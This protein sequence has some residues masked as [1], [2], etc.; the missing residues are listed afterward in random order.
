MGNSIE[1][2]QR[3][4]ANSV[5]ERLGSFLA[6]SDSRRSKTVELQDA[7]PESMIQRVREEAADSRQSEADKAGQVELSDRERKE[8]DFTKDGVNVPFARSVKG[9]ADNEGVTDWLQ[10]ADFDLSVD[11]NRRVLKDAS[12]EERGRSGLGKSQDKR[13][14]ARTADNKR[15]RRQQA[16]GAKGPAFGGDSE[17][18]GFLREEQQFEDDLFDINLRGDSGPTGQDYNRLEEAHESRSERAKRMD[19]RRS[20]EVTRD[21][22]LWAENKAKYDYP[23]VDTVQPAELHSERSRT[24]R[25]RDEEEQAPIADSRQ[26][27]ALNPDQ[28]D[29]PGVDTKQRPSMGDIK[30]KVEETM[31]AKN[32]VLVEARARGGNEAMRESTLFGRAQSEDVSLDPAEARGEAMTDSIDTTRTDP[33]AGMNAGFADVPEAMEAFAAAEED[34]DTDD[35]GF[36]DGFGDDRDKQGSMLDFGMETDATQHRESRQAEAEASEFG[37]D[38]RSE[39]VFEPMG[40][41]DSDQSGLEGFGGGTRENESLFEDY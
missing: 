2:G 32:D 21:P 30:E 35:S 20:A 41:D 25:R 27:W 36:L 15:K 22:L 6:D 14:I 40:F 18:I 11:E 4:V 17:A 26:Q 5:R 13:D 3:Q 38:D 28:Y 7:V 24:A 39:E 23:G 10:F 29:W 31:M 34:R 12:R 37:I 8:I 16:E 33:N 19:E 1:F 9:V